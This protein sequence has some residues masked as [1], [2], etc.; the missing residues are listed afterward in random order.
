MFRFLA[1][2]VVAGSVFASGVVRGVVTD[3][4]SALIP[5]SEVR[6]LPLGSGTTKYRVKTGD[7]G[8][9]TVPD[10]SAGEYVVRAYHAGFMEGAVTVT[11]IDGEIAD[12]G[13][14]RLRIAPC[15]APTV[16]DCF[17]VSS[18]S[19]PPTAPDPVIVRGGA[20]LRV[21]CGVDLDWAVVSCPD[22]A[23]PLDSRSDFQVRAGG[24]RALY[25]IPVNGAKVSDCE[26]TSDT[27]SQ[28]RIDGLGPGND[29]C[30][31][32]NEKRRSHVFISGTHVVEPGADEVRLWIV[33]RK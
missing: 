32:T 8:E 16:L 2:V 29:W 3:P 10:V 27:Y 19:D 7:D 22:G 12:A 31:E 18:S 25:L 28:I 30:V 15:D 5:R 14:V 1:T 4:S 9:F 6:L 24:D 21:G 33:T 11:V 17:Y 20:S 13:Q 23:S 26:K